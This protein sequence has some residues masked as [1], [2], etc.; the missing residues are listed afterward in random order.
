MNNGVV[1]CKIMQQIDSFVIFAGIFVTLKINNQMKIKINVLFLAICVAFL[2]ISVNAFCNE[3][4]TNVSS[5]DETLWAGIA[6]IVS[7]VAALV[8]KK[9]TGIIQGA[10]LLIKG[11]FTKKK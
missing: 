2:S 3:N 5:S 6:L 8:S 10:F 9:Y 1:F 4:I 7:E 11:I